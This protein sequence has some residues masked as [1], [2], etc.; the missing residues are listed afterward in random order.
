MKRKLRSVLS[1]V[2]LAVFTLFTLPGAFGSAPQDPAAPQDSSQNAPVPSKAEKKAARAEAGRDIR[3]FSTVGMG[4]KVSTLGIGFETATPVS[5][6]T[7][8]RFGANFFSYDRTFDK[9]GINYNGKLTLRSVETL[10]DYFPFGGFHL[11]PGLL[12]Y[13]GNNVKATASVP[14]GQ[15]FDLGDVTYQSS[16]TTPITGSG[17]LEFNKVAPVVMF[18]FGNLV[19][20][21]RH[22]S[23]SFEMGVAFHGSPRASLSLAGSACDVTGVNCRNVATDSTVLSNLTSEVN[24]LNNTASPYKVWPIISLG[25]GYKF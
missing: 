4:I 7:N 14:T 9:D 3:P 18:G 11:S 10:F 13:N 15:T 25:F 2:I 8:L 12:I 16:A 6:R 5:R 23:V 1:F 19:P 22:I 20:R 24:K 17:K 21:T